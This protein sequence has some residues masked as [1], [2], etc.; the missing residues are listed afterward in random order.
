MVNK[1]QFRSAAKRAVKNIIMHGDTDIFPLPF[2][3]HAFFDK[4]DALVDLVCEYDQDFK[5]IK[6]FF[7]TFF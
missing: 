7:L 1:E 4:E 2:E 5:F 6:C 3:S